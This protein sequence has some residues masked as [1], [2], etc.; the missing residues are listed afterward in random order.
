M[1]DTGLSTEYVPDVNENIQIASG[2]AV[3]ISNT[4]QL[5]QEH[6]AA[7]LIIQVDMTPV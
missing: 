2:F 1:P 5:I 7:N 4:V 6:T 3:S